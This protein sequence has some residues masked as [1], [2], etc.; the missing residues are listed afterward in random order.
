M[1]DVKKLLM[2]VTKT[3]EKDKE[4][5]E[6]GLKKEITIQPPSNNDDKS[7]EPKKERG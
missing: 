6:E 2:E 1:T 3:F 5:I 4:K 7:E